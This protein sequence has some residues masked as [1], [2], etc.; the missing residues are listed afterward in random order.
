M[1]RIRKIQELGLDVH[2]IWSH[3]IVAKLEI[4]RQ[5]KTFF[6]DQFDMGP[7]VIR[8]ALFGGRT[9]PLKLFA[10]AKN[11]RIIKDK[12]FFLIIKVI[13]FNQSL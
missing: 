9:G 3:E 4:D 13:I 2:L 8:D 10:E 7:I 11:G 5:M 12:G 1:A 6:D